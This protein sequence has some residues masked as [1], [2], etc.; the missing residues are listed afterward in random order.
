MVTSLVTPYHVSFYDESSTEW[1]I[2]EVVIDVIFLIDIILS[3]MTAFHN[4][5]EELVDKRK[6]IAC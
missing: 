4:S 6:K 3:F 2:L 1:T 5:L